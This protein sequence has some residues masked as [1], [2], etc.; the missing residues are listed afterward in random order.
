MFE[1]LGEVV[2]LRRLQ[3]GFT[4]ERVARMAKVS[5]R[6]LSLLEDGRNVSLL[7]LMKIARALEITELPI[8]ELRL[9]GTQPEVDTIV[10]AAD[11]LHQVKQT[12]PGLEAAIGQIRQASVS[13]DQ[14]LDGILASGAT[15]EEVVES[16][17]RVEKLPFGERK[18]AGE[19]VRTLGQEEPPARAERPEIDD[20][21]AERQGN[22]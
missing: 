15:A 7:F 16:L 17:R 2:R 6:Q 20:V 4:Q 5:R 11:V 1:P 19:T 10:H 3:L 21:V 12:L 14:M 22:G 13:L 8:G 18:A 9:R